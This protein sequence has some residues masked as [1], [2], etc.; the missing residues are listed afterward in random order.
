MDRPGRHSGPDWDRLLAEGVHRKERTYLLA[1]YFEVRIAYQQLYDAQE[2]FAEV[3]DRVEA[4]MA[5]VEPLGK[6]PVPPEEW[7]TPP[8]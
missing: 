5:R 7:E 2:H 4:A 3:W 6:P 1:L 8:S